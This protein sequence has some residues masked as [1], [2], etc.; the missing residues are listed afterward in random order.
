M[1]ATTPDISKIRR[2]LLREVWPHEAYDFTAW[3]E[4][5]LDVL[6]DALDLNLVDASREQAAGSFSVDLVAEDE[7]GNRVVIENQLEKSNHDHAELL[8]VWSVPDAVYAVIDDPPSP[9]AFEEIVR[10][11]S[12]AV[13]AGVRLDLDEPWI[14]DAG[15]KHAVIDRLSP[16]L[17]LPGANSI[18]AILR[19]EETICRGCYELA[20]EGPC[21][22]SATS[23]RP[24]SE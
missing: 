20:H 11:S 3:L 18:A 12:F 19:A 17:R 9:G 15:G 10:E 13:D 6:N 23:A 21:R 5:N 16:G 22:R 14:V 8:R 7:A 1:T 2:V 24:E 4:E